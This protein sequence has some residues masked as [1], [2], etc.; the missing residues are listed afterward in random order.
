[1][2]ILEEL[3]L[4]AE[5]RLQSLSFANL[6]FVTDREPSFTPLSLAT[7]L[8]D[9]DLD[10]NQKFTL[11]ELT[12]RA[13]ISNLHTLETRSEAIQTRRQRLIERIE[14]NSYHTAQRVHEVWL[15]K[16][17][18]DTVA[19]LKRLPRIIAETTSQ[20]ASMFEAA[21]T[22][23]RQMVS[24]FMSHPPTVLTFLNPLP[25]VAHVPQPSLQDL[26]LVENDPHN[27]F[28]LYL[29]HHLDEAGRTLDSLAASPKG[30]VHLTHEEISHAAMTIQNVVVD[31]WMRQVMDFNGFSVRIHRSEPGVRSTLMSTFH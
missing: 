15:R 13:C 3:A 6:R 29:R 27:A 4:L 17:F 16:Q 10:T 1:M 22:R 9:G 18:D 28:T 8:Q 11:Y 31:I 5:S 24:A 2:K 30:F 12:A 14:D 23:T 7:S 26:Q 20:F 25:A 21:R 19:E